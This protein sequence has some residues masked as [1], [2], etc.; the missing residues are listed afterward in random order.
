MPG[1]SEPKTTW[2]NP[3]TWFGESE[4]KAKGYEQPRS[5]NEFLSQPRV[6][7]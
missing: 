1:K 3:A 6:P 2:Y 5:V 7:Y 4:E